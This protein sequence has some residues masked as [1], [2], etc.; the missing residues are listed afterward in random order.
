MIF[1][2]RAILLCACLMAPAACTQLTPAGLLA[3]ARLDPLRTPPDQIVIALSV[4]QEVQLSDGDAVIQIVF[5]EDGREPI[6]VTAPLT[7]REGDG[8]APP[9]DGLGQKVYVAEVEP[10]GAARF[11][12]AQAEI[13][14]RR[15]AGAEGKGSLRVTV[16]GGCHTGPPLEA[17]PLSTWLRT[18]GDT[19]FV[20]L[21]RRADVFEIWPGGRD[22]LLECAERAPTQ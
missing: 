1:K 20:R 16:R 7:L 14:Q 12:E 4:P 15:E 19:R 3:A 6:D 8:T 5:S 9:P 13:L 11:A 21:T 10:A 22:G 2:H 18:R 17:F